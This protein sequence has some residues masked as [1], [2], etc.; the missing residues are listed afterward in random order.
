MAPLRATPKYKDKIPTDDPLEFSDFDFD[1]LVREVRLRLEV[2]HIAY[3]KDFPTRESAYVEVLMA[4]GRPLPGYARTVNAHSNGSSCINRVSF[5]P[6]VE[7]FGFEAEGAL[8]IHTARSWLVPPPRFFSMLMIDP[9]DQ[10]DGYSGA[11]HILRFREVFRLFADAHGPR[12]PR[13]LEL[14]MSTPLA[15]PAKKV[16]EPAP[17]APVVFSMGTDDAH[18]LGLR[19]RADIEELASTRLADTPDSEEFK[20]ALR[21]LGEAIVSCTERHVF[22]MQRG[23]LIIVDNRRCGHGRSNAQR[24]GPD[25][26]ANSRELWSSTIE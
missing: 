3:V 21:C 11:S 24:H 23:D 10:R 2:D 7:L 17:E 26:H 6:G 14:L 5:S 20:A 18:D 15:M 13:I 4:L 8:P 12:Y 16:M 9:G 25:G 1:A 22:Q 19:Y